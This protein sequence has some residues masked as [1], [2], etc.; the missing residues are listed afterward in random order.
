M[1]VTEF[2]D[3]IDRLGEDL[4]SWPEEH[5]LIAEQLLTQ[6]GEAQALLARARALRNALS[7][8]PVRAPKGLVDRIVD[9]AVKS[10]PESG[11]ERA[12]GETARG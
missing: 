8:Q 2:G 3:L 4:S 12:E 6:S 5:R 10:E 9:A 7:A 11:A 1:D